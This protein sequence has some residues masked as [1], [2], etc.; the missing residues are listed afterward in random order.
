MCMFD[1]AAQI[2]RRKMYAVQSLE[3]LPKEEQQHASPGADDEKTDVDEAV[4]VERVKRAVANTLPKNLIARTPLQVSPRMAISEV[5]SP[6]L[7]MLAEDGTVTYC[8]Q[9]V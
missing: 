1:V 3:R 5:C 2:R 8:L 7:S 9:R 6:T 4:L